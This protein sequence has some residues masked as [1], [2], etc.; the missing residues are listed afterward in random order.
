MEQ[1]EMPQLLRFSIWSTTHCGVVNE[2]VRQN[3]GLG[4]TLYREPGNAVDPTTVV[5]VCDPDMTAEVVG[6]EP[7]YADHDWPDLKYM[8]QRIGHVARA[9]PLKDWVWQRLANASI[10]A[11]LIEDLGLVIRPFDLIKDE[12]GLVIG[13]FEPY[14]PMDDDIPF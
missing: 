6:G 10:R 12:P 11:V 9:E 13:P 2:L 7:G 5:V 4:V 8:G 14:N 3:G 1:Q